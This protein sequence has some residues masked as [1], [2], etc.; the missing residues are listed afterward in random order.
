MLKNEKKKENDDDDRPRRRDDGDPDDEDDDGAYPTKPLRIRGKKRV[1]K[2]GNC[3]YAPT[4]IDTEGLDIETSADEKRILRDRIA[5]M[6]GSTREGFRDGF[7]QGVNELRYFKQGYNLGFKEA[8]EEELRE[9]RAEANRKPVIPLDPTL[10]SQTQSI[11]DKVKGFVDGA[12]GGGVAKITGAVNNVIGGL[13]AKVSGGFH[14]GGSL[15]LEEGEKI[16]KQQKHTTKYG[17]DASDQPEIPDGQGLRVG[18]GAA[19]AVTVADTSCVMCQFYVEHINYLF[20]LNANNPANAQVLLQKSTLTEDEQRT[21]ALLAES[22][23]LRHNRKKF[24]SKKELLERVHAHK[25]A[26][27]HHQSHHQSQSHVHA[28]AKDHTHAHS[29]AKTHSK[30]HSHSPMTVSP[31]VGQLPTDRRDKLEKILSNPPNLAPDASPQLPKWMQPSPVYQQLIPNVYQQFSQ[32]CAQHVPF[33]LMDTCTPLMT[34]FKD[35]ADALRFGDR[36][37]QVCRSVVP[38]CPAGTYIDNAPHVNT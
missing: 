2:D 15:F 29:K 28:H 36:A 17:A 37:D 6:T 26:K 34:K 22:I 7:E 27:S 25:K 9:Q 20:H 33:S 1:C 30:T 12:I 16:T 31:S 13:G 18:N 3:W 14:F 38:S 24:E 5:G 32:L 21:L 19:D 4:N 8:K 10:E 35:I 23:D 11:G